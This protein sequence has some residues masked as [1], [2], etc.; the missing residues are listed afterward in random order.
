VLDNAIHRL[1]RDDDLLRV[2]HVETLPLDRQMVDR[3]PFAGTDL[4]RQG[5]RSQ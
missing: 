2:L 5:L 3:K 1:S 4:D